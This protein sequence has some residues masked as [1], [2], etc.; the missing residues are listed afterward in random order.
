[1]IMSGHTAMSQ[2]NFNFSAVLDETPIS[3]D[4][5]LGPLLF[6]GAGLRT[7][8]VEVQSRKQLAGCGMLF[9]QVCRS[10]V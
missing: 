5:D 7:N 10:F 4:F 2:S 8:L 1:M 3:V 6:A 9:D